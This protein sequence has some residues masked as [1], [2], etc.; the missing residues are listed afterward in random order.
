MASIVE[1]SRFAVWLFPVFAFCYKP[2]MN[3]DYS[4]AS[5]STDSVLPRPKKS[6]KLKK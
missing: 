3:L 2:S 1:G 4:R 6:E 5:V